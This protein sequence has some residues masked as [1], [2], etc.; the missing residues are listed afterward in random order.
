M[1]GVFIAG[2]CPV[3]ALM[4]AWGGMQAHNFTIDGAIRY[5]YDI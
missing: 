4:G 3:F 5:V 1:N 2:A